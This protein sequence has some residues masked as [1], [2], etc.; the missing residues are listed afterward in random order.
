MR[1]RIRYFP[2]LTDDEKE[3]LNYKQK[4]ELDRYDQRTEH[5]NQRFKRLHYLTWDIEGLAEIV[6]YLLYDSESPESVE[7]QLLRRRFLTPRDRQLITALLDRDTQAEIAQ[8]MECSR[9][10]VSRHL[11]TLRL[12]LLRNGYGRGWPDKSKE[13]GCL[14]G[15]GEDGDA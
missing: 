4:C 12:K 5:S 11:K 6:S 14:Q 15:I 8:D 9:M 3:L 7:K 2:T 13:E 10:T 1:Y